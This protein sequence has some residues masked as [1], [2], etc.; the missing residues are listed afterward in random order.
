MSSLSLPPGALEPA[1]L[2]ARRAHRARAV[3]ASARRR[4]RAEPAIVFVLAT[5]VFTALGIRT[6][7]ALHLLYP[8]A[9]T[10]LTDAFIAW[11]NQ[12]PRF[13]AIGFVYPPLQSVALLPFA[14]LRPLATSDV[15][16]PLFSALCAAATLSTLDRTL[17]L[18]GLPRWGRLGLLLAFL[19]NPLWLDYATN[20]SATCLTMALLA[21]AL[22]NF[23]RWYREGAD[24]VRPLGAC[25][26]WLALGFL[27]RYETV[28]WLGLIAVTVALVR[29]ARG[30]APAEI[31]A[32]EAILLAPIVYI[33]LIWSAISTLLGGGGALSWVTR[34]GAERIAGLG[35][36]GR[37][38]FLARAGGVIDVM[39]RSSPLLI[40]V[41]I[42]LLLAAVLLRRPIL[43][44]LAGTVIV[45]AL[46]AILRMLILPNP[47]LLAPAYEMVALVPALIGAGWLIGL[48]PPLRRGPS[49]ISRLPGALAVLALLAGLTVSLFSADRLLAADGN[50]YDR[51]YAGTLASGFTRLGYPGAG[52]PLGPAAL[53]ADTRALATFLEAAVYGKETVLVDEFAFPGLILSMHTTAPFRT[54]A[55]DGT[56]YW[57]RLLD[58]P[59]SRGKLGYLIV[60]NPRLTAPGYPHDLISRRYPG[61]YAGAVPQMTVIYRNPLAA[62]VE[63]DRP[64][65]PGAAAPQASQGH[66]A[67]TPALF[68]HLPGL[69]R[70]VSFLPGRARPLTAH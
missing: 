20:G 39:W 1:A 21:A 66:S 2:P 10:R 60:A 25:G 7:V 54:R 57:E 53:S 15:A 42:L 32:L 4:D 17:T 35:Y 41:P 37:T 65:Q 29:R 46:G 44:A 31:V 45:G 28:L 22:H 26:L 34:A 56:A 70:Q 69:A 58:A 51:A 9:L 38:G 61:A 50:V 40:V 23:C 18:L 16:L 59:L 6:T 13:R 64:G 19:L 43:L 24:S 52:P 33:F 30:A 36:G 67:P 27:A 47:E 55:A 68:G 49:R 14:L 8:D 3:R 62:V 12:P 63:L 5:I 48:V 11:W